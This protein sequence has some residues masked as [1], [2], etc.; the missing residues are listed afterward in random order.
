MNEFELI[1]RCFSNWAVTNPALLTGIGDDCLVWQ[2]SQPLVVSTDTAVAGRHFPT[3]ASA[4]QVAQRAFL[5]ALSDLAAMA[6]TPA[7]FTL[8]IT[9]PSA[10]SET[11]LLSFAGRL[12]QLAEQY[13]MVLAGG[14][15][16]A[17]EQLTVTI[18]VHG[19]SQQPVLRSSAQA[20]DDIW[21]TG[22]LGQAAA[23]LPF[24]LGQARAPAPQ[25]WLQAYWQPA[26]PIAFAQAVAKRINS[27]IDI[28]DGL[29]GDAQHLAERSAQ[30]LHIDLDLLP[31]DA[32]LAALGEQGLKYAVSGGDDYQLLFTAASHQRDALAAQ[33]ELYN[34][35]LSRIGTVSG[36]EPSVQWYQGGQQT[37]LP[38]CGY[39]HFE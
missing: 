30:A 22:T 12:R 11:W 29:I 38:W 23:A 1:K 37:A 31:L 24:V 17:G 36:A 5:P 20:G 16:T 32:E 27:A 8:A 25:C 13:Q 14:D 18:A 3:Q 35:R 6:A 26:P 9:L 7:F 2:A 39:Q 28:S 19:H 4:S 33:A 34:T 21:V 10:T 15:T